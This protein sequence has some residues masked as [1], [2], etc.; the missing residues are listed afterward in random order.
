MEVGHL[1]VPVGR[2]DAAWIRPGHE[3]LPAADLDL[4]LEGVGPVGV[5]VVR[6]TPVH[7][8]NRH[9]PCSCRDLREP[10]GIDEPVVNVKRETT[11]VGDLVIAGSML[12]G[13]RE[14]HRHR[15]F[16]RPPQPDRFG[17]PVRA[18]GLCAIVVPPPHRH[19]QGVRPAGHE[20]AQ[21]HRRRKEA[22]PGR[23]ALLGRLFRQTARRRRLVQIVVLVGVRPLL[24][25][26]AGRNQEPGQ[27]PVRR[28][29]PAGQP[30]AGK[31]VVRPRT[32]QVEVQRFD[33]AFA[34]ARGVDITT[35]G[36]LP[37]HTV[38]AVSCRVMG[39]FSRKQLPSPAFT[40][41]P[42]G[43]PDSP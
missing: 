40:A 34:H 18:R 27:I 41:A 24:L 29:H 15:P 13:R 30:L 6:R 12:F 4:G 31:G 36:V 11:G 9:R 19:G 39:T 25:L 28:T 35:R 1:L 26:R 32:D 21:S 43:S 2:P 42:S 8:K 38:P 5:A 37:R 14:R 16:V 17:L 10:V 22:F 20:E 3:R 23:L 7:Q 33:Q